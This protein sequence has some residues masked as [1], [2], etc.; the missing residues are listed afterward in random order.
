MPACSSSSSQ[1]SPKHNRR[2][3][4]RFRY[5]LAAPRAFFEGF[6]GYDREGML[7]PR[8]ELPETLAFYAPGSQQ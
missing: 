3:G 7:V 8:A 1:S 2:L 5:G 4:P 6:L